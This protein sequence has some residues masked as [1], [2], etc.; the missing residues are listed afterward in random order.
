APGSGAM[1]L[2]SEIFE[3]YDM[4]VDDIDAEFVGYAQAADLLRNGKIVGAQVMSALPTSAAI[5]MLSTTNSKIIDLSD[6]AIKR[7]TEK[8]DWLVEFTIPADM[9]DELDKDIQTVAQPSVL[10]VSK[11]MPD[12]IVYELAKQMWENLEPLHDT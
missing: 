1:S 12:D 4:T 2:S 8:N 9:Y 5:E 11:D 6:E 3:A 7:L 10:I